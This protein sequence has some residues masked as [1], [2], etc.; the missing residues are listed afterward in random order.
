MHEQLVFLVFCSALLC[1]AILVFVQLCSYVF[2]LSTLLLC[3]FALEQ[4][5]AA[6]AAT[7][8]GRS[9]GRG[10][11]GVEALALPGLAR[12]GLSALF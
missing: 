6:P 7:K 2:L 4:D 9:Q 11:M 12:Q 1:L 8:R 10:S 3:V 5:S